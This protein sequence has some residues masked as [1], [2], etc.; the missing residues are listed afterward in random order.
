[1]KKISSQTL[2]KVTTTPAVLGL[3]LLSATAYAQDAP[4]NDED[5]GEAIIVTG[6]RILR[7]R[8]DTTQPTTIIG[9][10]AIEDRGLTNIG[11]ALDT[12]PAF[13]PPP[14]SAV[15]GQAGS[16]GS[17]QTFVDYFGLGSQRTLTLVNG[18]RYV[19]SNTAS[20]F[21]P[22]A[23][24]SQ[25]DLN[26]I[27]SLLVDRIETVAVGGAPIYGSDAI[28]GTVNII[29]KDKFEGLQLSGQYGIAERGDAADYRLQALAGTSFAGG[30]GNILAA[31]EYN[32][33]QG[34]LYTDR[35]VTSEGL[36]FGAP[37]DP[38]YPFSN[39]LFNHRRIN[40]M[41]EYGIPLA[42][43]DIS[44]YGAG[45]YDGAG[46][47]LAFNRNGDLIPI[48]FGT[49]TGSFV[50]YSGG[51]G[52]NLDPLSNLRSPVE[53]YLGNVQ[54]N[55]ELTD[56]IRAF[57]E[58]SYARSKGTTLRDQPV[59]NSWLFDDAGE[60]DG[61]LIIPLSNPFLSDA[62][63]STIAQSLDADGDGVPDQDFFYL[64]R[65]NTDLV[66]G[67]GSS[68][69]ELYRIVGG[70][71]GQLD[72]GGRNF[73]WEVSGNYG[74]SKTV[75]S[76]RELVEQNFQNALNGCPTG[77]ISSP[78]ATISATCAA[79]NPFGQQNSQAVK[80]YLTTV[81]QPT[82]LNEQWVFNA[83]ISGNLFSIWAGDIGVALGY[84]HRNEKAGFDPGAFFYGTV[85]P[86]D[87]TGPRLQY[88]R[89]IPIDPV[90]GS[91]NTD[92]VFGEVRVPLISSQ[93]D[94]PFANLLEFSGAARYVNNS[95][96]G[97]DLTWS[98][99]GRWQP[100]ED[101]TIRGNYTRSIRSP[102]VTELFNPTSAT[103][104]TAN[105]P[106]D[107]R[108]LTQG[109]DPAVR[110]ANCAAAGLPADFVSDI[111]SATKRGTVSGNTDLRNEKAN[112]WTIGAILTPRAMPGFSLSVDWVRIDLQDAI[113]SVDAEQTMEACYDD[114]SYPTAICDA[115]DRSPSGQVEFF[116]AGYRNAASYNYAGLVADLRYRFQTPFLGADSNVTLRGSYQYI[117][118]LEQRVG[119]GDRTILRGG[120]GYSKHQFTGSLS[121]DNG[122]VDY[123][124]QAR[125]TGPAVVDADA[126]S[127]DYDYFHV[128]STVVL[129]SSIGFRVQDQFRLRF[130]I[131]NLLDSKPPFPVPANGGVVTYF[132]Q[133][134]GRYFKVAATVGF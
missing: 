99:G 9:A 2:L 44:G 3:A 58:F 59:Y 40:I 27:P 79:F 62:A 42:A 1:M 28:A 130:I 78:I 31:F 6:S 63:R 18:R 13:A 54:A 23:A 30:R 77:A 91:Y 131:D 83:N 118:K 45:I 7:T 69:V 109:P 4:A 129:N 72:I 65:A 17:G 94:V 127:A 80:D 49:P 47:E 100:V 48:D 32:K 120:I 8:L 132:D 86:D 103:F 60:P 11:D 12:I 20:I 105:D 87:P 16:F 116:R 124:L 102:A 52:L 112:S 85:A 114:P 84:E 126:T 29:L 122:P 106:C 95:L 93:M 96:A 56:G 128:N 68:T 22:V 133:V 71:D 97:G 66:S 35:R 110:Q 10:E 43:D 36:F 25:V 89:S 107:A 53:R 119:E 82:A 117:D 33:S 21:G 88:G 41:S 75:G 76:S 26:T 81:A 101:I 19:S 37:T 73:H 64:G 67:R 98:A 70:L 39:Q 34:L 123:Y 92:E 14:S 108:F 51:N 74:R 15:G 50:D 38:D 121:Y 115:I 111:V 57:A 113:L 46:N 90:Q 55:Y 104:E 134:L 125:Y 5:Q 24:G 61:N